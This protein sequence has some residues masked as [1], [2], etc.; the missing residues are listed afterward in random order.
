MANLRRNLFIFLCALGICLIAWYFVSKH[1]MQ[2]PKATQIANIIQPGRP[3]TAFE[4]YDDSGKPF[5]EKALKGHWTVM[6]FGYPACP[7]ICPQT[8]TQ[9][10]EVWN[11]YKN[12]P[13][14]FVFASIVPE[15]PDSGNLKA[16]VQKFHPDFI[17]ITG[18][19]AAINQLSDQLGIY[20]KQQEDRIDHSSSLMV[21]D[22]H[23]R[24]VAVLS[25]PF[26]TEQLVQ[27]LN[28]IMEL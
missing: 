27:D 10:S 25:P 8:L 6:F 19:P 20:V 22:P 24:L 1:Y 2:Q 4:L 12:P 7:D 13:A 14:H 3:L 18:T 11:A 26:N 21:I 16:F 23:G 15:P 17:G 5:T 9:V 28:A